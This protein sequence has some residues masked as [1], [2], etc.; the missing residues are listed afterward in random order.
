[1]VGARGLEEVSPGLGRPGHQIVQSGAPHG[2][3]R[4]RSVWPDPGRLA[5]QGHQ[6]A[7]TVSPRHTPTMVRESQ[8]WEGSSEVPGSLLPLPVP[9]TG[10]A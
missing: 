7:G 4:S 3:S 2:L 9:H 6:H 10:G 1:M 5:T 8:M